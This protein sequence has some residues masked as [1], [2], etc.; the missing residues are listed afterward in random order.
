MTTE[1]NTSAEVK[2]E[3]RP[4]NELLNLKTYQGMTDDEIKSVIDWYVK[5][6]RNDEETKAA[7]SA[8]I[9]SMNSTTEAYAKA[10]EES[11]NVLKQLLSK[12]LN[13]VTIEDGVEDSTGGAA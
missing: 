5:Q 6:A 3:Q 2:P 11:N 10:A 4:V 13:L 12:P 8:I 7:Q 9:V 1:D